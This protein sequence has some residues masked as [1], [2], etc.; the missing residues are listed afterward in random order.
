MRT[1]SEA[2]PVE[3]TTRIPRFRLSDAAVIAQYI[4]DLRQAS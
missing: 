1:Q 4:R 2:P 3:E